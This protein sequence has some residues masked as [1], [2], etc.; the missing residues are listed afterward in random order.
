MKAVIITEFGAE[1]KVADVPVPEPGPAELLVRLHA[2]GLNPF[3][4]KVIDGALRGVVKHGFPL[5]MG[6]DG[7]GVVERVG[8]G[9]TEFAPGD[10]VY[11]QFM[12][13]TEGRGSY[14]EYALIPE[15]GKVAHIPE[16]LPFTVAA[17]L[18][19]ASAAAYGAIKAAGLEPGQVILINGASGGVGQSAIQFAAAEGAR[20]LATATPEVADHLRN[21]GAD[22]II[23]FTAAPTPDQV[24]DLHRDGVD[25]ILDLITPQ[26]GDLE[27]LTG[28]LT[29]GGVL[30]NTNFAADVDA[31]AAR[32]IRGVNLSSSPTRADLED[33]AALADAGT[34]RITIDAELSLDDAPAAV[35][36]A[37]SGEARGKTILVP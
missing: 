23:D 1:P 28:L 20:V 14:A 2:A 7:A 11:G 34:L 27:P 15:G 18:P 35:G 29:P 8:Q 3:D 31:L 9:V 30:V 6:S 33:L 16:S 26:G 37:R 17:A 25:A 4:W 5:V 19:T 13:L 21:L 32:E 36:R 10:T 22:E 24:R 12:Q